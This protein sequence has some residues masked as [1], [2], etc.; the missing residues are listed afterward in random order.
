VAA[1]LD[2]TPAA[3]QARSSSGRAAGNIATSRGRHL[4]APHRARDTSR[5]RS[6]PPP[7]DTPPGRPRARTGTGASHPADRR[8]PTTTAPLRTRRRPGPREPAAD[9]LPRAAPEPRR[10]RGSRTAARRVPRSGPRHA[11]HDRRAA[12]P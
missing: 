8:P 4:R 12:E 9:L 7:P 11:P 3:A 10:H 5:P 6:P 1:L 2:R